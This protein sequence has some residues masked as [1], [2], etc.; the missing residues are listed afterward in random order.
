MDSAI[1]A[2]GSN[3]EAGLWVSAISYSNDGGVYTI[4]IGG[5]GI[6]L[7]VEYGNDP[8]KV[9]TISWSTIISKLS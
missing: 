2:A 7:W 4:Q 8:Q 3:Q 9:K 6:T 5:K 1:E